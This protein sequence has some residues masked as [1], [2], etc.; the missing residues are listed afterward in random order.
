LAWDVHFWLGKYTTQDEAGTAAYKTVELDTLLKGA[1]VQHREVQGYESDMFLGYFKNEIR[2]L[3]GGVDTGFR[4]VEPDKYE[5]RLLHLKG[6]KKVRVTQVPLSRDSLNSGDVFILDGGVNLYQF[7]GKQAG[8]MEKNKGAELSKAIADERKGLPKVH[9]IDEGGKLPAEFWKLLGGEGPI[10][11]ATEGGDDSETGTKGFEKTLYRLSDA[12]GKLTF[13]K[14]KDVKRSSLDSN[15]VFV[16]DTGAEVFAWIGKKSS[17][18][19]KQKALQ[20]AQDYLHQH[21]RPAHLPISRILEG[22]EN[23]VFEASLH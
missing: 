4:H 12:S 20:Y 1:P 16:L 11:S 8:P 6:K 10:K 14:V 5:P 22:G 21:N 15:D 9:V 2:L 3:D 18:G 23:E 7:N 19:E 17:V 13:T